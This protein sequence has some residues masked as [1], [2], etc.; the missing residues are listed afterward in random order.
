MLTH[1]HLPGVVF[2]QELRF[3]AY[4]IPHA[5]SRVEGTTQDGRRALAVVGLLALIQHCFDTHVVHHALAECA[6][7]DL[8][9][10][11]ACIG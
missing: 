10:D 6:Q 9:L 1:H 2:S 5:H 11:R 3:Q 7:F 4:N 8:Y